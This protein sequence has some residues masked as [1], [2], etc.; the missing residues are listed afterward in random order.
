MVYLP[1]L[2]KSYPAG[3]NPAKHIP[4]SSEATPHETPILTPQ[5]NDPGTLPTLP[6]STIERNPEELKDIWRGDDRDWA[7]CHGALRSLARDGRKLELWKHWIDPNGKPATRRQAMWTGETSHLLNGSATAQVYE[8]IADAPF[9]VDI[10]RAPVEFI[11]P[12]LEANVGSSL[13]VH[14]LADHIRVFQAEDI[15]SLFMFP[16]SR[17]RF[18][19]ML[20]DA[21]LLDCIPASASLGDFWSRHKASG[22]SPLLHPTS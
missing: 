5:P 1:S 22:G 2:A 16:D 9:E 3:V 14:V 8:L 15:V 11:R 12:V 10:T 17:A 4:T 18:I 6:S 13:R 20:K 19:D 7:R 21:G